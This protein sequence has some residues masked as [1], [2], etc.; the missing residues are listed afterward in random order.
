M[1]KERNF[2]KEEMTPIV[3]SLKGCFS[4]PENFDYKKELEKSLA[5][6]YLYRIERAD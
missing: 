2:E 3:S 1:T 4:V 5:N 6:K